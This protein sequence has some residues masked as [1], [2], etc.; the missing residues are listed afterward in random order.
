MTRHCAM[1]VLFVL[2][3]TVVTVADPSGQNAE[4]LRDAQNVLLVFFV[5]ASNF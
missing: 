4:Y 2:I 5:D 1:Q 3:T